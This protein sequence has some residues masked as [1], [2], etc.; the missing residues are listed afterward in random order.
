MLEASFVALPDIALHSETGESNSEK[1]SL[2]VQRLYQIDSAA[3]GQTEIADKHIKFLFRTEVARRLHVVS[4]LH[5]IAAPPE[6]IRKRS[7]RIFVVFDEQNAHGVA[8]QLRRRKHWR[9]SCIH[10]FARRKSQRESRPFISTGAFRGDRPGVRFDKS[11]ADRKTKA[12][13]PKL[14]T[15]ALLKSIENLRQ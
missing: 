14:C 7:V 4:R 3:I 5:M 11:F 1:W 8:L 13:A 12:Q 15:A 10:L 2:R 9:G 6:Q